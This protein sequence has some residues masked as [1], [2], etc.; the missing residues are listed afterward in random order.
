MSGQEPDEEDPDRP[1][2]V[3]GALSREDFRWLGKVA[4]LTRIPRLPLLLIFGLAAAA[5]GAWWV[6]Q[7]Q[8]V[9]D[10]D[11]D[12]VQLVALILSVIA[13][14]T[15]VLTPA[16]LL[17]RDPSALR[18]RTA[19]FGGLALL[20]LQQVL[21]SVGGQT[22]I[23]LEGSQSIV[24]V[25]RG[26]LPFVEPVG[27]A[28]VAYGLLVMRIERPRPGLMLAGIL[29]V[30]AA[31]RLLPDLI[32]ALPSQGSLQVDWWSLA[33][34]VT[35]AF[36]VW[37]AVDAWIRREPPELFWLLLAA[38][39]PL[40]ILT[41]LLALPESVAVVVYEQ[42]TPWTLVALATLTS[43]LPMFLAFVAYLRYAPIAPTGGDER[44]V[45]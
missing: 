31:V 5:V 12:P 8:L 1:S 28:L 42:S 39:L 17:W 23:D 20:A 45:G 34:A 13:A 9:G 36:A 32:A 35:T 41:A 24:G 29:G 26:S 33:I 43:V 7:Y 25:I 16:A 21:I 6:R 30:Y 2:E 18:T 4:A 15:T 11:V 37:V 19:L 38:A 27:G 14:M 44:V 40:T 22:M 3:V 10:P